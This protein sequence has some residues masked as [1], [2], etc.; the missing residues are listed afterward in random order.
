MAKAIFIG[1]NYEKVTGCKNLQKIPSVYAK[2]MMSTL[3]MPSVGLYR[4]S[5]CR[6]F[7]DRKASEIPG[8][9]V[10]IQ[11]PSRMNVTKALTDMVSNAEK[12][13][14]LLFYFCGHGANEYQTK[15]GALKTLNSALSAPDS[16]YSDELATIFKPLDPSISMTFLIHACY[17]GAMFSYNPNDTKGIALVS[18]GPDIPSAVTKEADAVDFT[19][20]IRDSIIKK[21]PKGNPSHASWPSYQGVSDDVKKITVE[22]TTPDGK[23]FKGHAEMYRAPKENPATRKFLQ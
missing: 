16:L 6:F 1:I 5:E 12:G 11:Q 4:D 13:D 3:T 20:R 22:G 9:K 18:C 8:L 21:L 2:S 10:G 15:R 23:P 19:T 7:T 14:K 17:S